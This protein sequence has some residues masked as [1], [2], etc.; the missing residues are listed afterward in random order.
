MDQI[1]QLEDKNCQTDEKQ[2]LTVCS[3]MR[4]IK[5]MYTENLKVKGWTKE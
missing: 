2:K 4:H 1:L 3:Y 5:Y